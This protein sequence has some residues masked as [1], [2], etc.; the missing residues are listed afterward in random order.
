MRRL[1][2]LPVALVAMLVLAACQPVTP[3]PPPP[4]P[5]PV[6][7]YCAPT[8]PTSAPGYQA[9]FDNLRRTYTEWGSADGAIPVTL[10]DGRVVWL[11]SDTYVGAVH[12]DGSIDPSDHLINNSFVV[13]SNNCFAPLMGGS[14]L[15]RTSLIANPAAGQVY[16]PASGYVENTSLGPVLRIV[17][18]RIQLLPVGGFAAV[19]LEL[20]TFS[21]PGL[22]QQGTPVAI[23]GAIPSRPLGATSFA[24]AG[25]GFVYFYGANSHL[26]APRTENLYVARA[27]L[28]S[29][30]DFTTWRFWNGTDWS[31]TSAAQAQSAT[32]ANVPAT[33]AP[34][35]VPLTVPVSQLWVTHS[36]TTA[37]YVGTAKVIDAFTGDVS[38]FSA[39]APEGPWTYVGQ[40]ADSTPYGI[41]YGAQT[42]VGLPGGTGATIVF[43][44]NTGGANI[45][46]YGPRFVPPSI[47]LP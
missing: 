4:P 42:L 33:P 29:T 7:Q 20:A 19:D 35:G 10:P 39:P 2:L 28:G 37:S 16:W 18:W 6:S 9:A 40:V 43:S 5:Q 27:P 26:D 11:F 31:S 41:S 14:P 30:N 21:L 32:F 45:N 23:P 12:A 8:T 3:T 25:D 34:N 1:W 46:A 38:L 36:P 47:A 44:N 13:Q 15:A 24:N 17:V 22:V